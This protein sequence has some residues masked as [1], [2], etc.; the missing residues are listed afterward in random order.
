MAVTPN[1]GW[2][3]PVATDYV[4]DGWEAIS[5]LGN[6]I[7][8]TVAGLSS[9]ALTLITAQAVGSAVS[10]VTISNC[11][12]STYDNYRIDYTNGTSSTDAEL[13]VSLGGI[14]T[15][16]NSNLIYRDYASGSLQG[17]G[18]NAQSSWKWLGVPRTTFVESHFDLYNP[19]LA[20]PKFAKGFIIVSSDGGSSH[21]FNASTT[22]ATSFT[23]TP[24]AGTITGGT[25]Y[26]YG[27]AKA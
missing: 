8:T 20:K 3:V 24:S 1:Y 22:Q 10:S 13:L 14:T 18:Q 11:F 26:V 4:K 27:Y 6:A 16:Y 7:D 17:V 19:N 12:S 5:D 23:L 25:V 9:G 2:P 21:H 15:G